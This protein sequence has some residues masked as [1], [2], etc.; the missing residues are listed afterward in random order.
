M[1][2]LTKIIGELTLAGALLLGCGEYIGRALDDRNASLAV[3]SSARNPIR[4]TKP[5]P[6]YTS[7]DYTNAT[8]N[9]KI[10]QGRFEPGFLEEVESLCQILDMN[11]MGLLSVIDYE[12]RGTFH[13]YIRNKGTFP[14]SVKKS[15]IKT[16]RSTATGLIQFTQ[17]TAEALGTTTESL[18][19]MSQH[20]QIPYLARYF[21]QHRK[22]QTNYSNPDDIALTI[23]HPA[24]VGQGSDHVIARRGRRSYHQNARL[25]NSPQDGRITAREYVQEALNR[26]YL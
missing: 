3:S 12:T 5:F 26:G 1:K 21:A 13:P 18:A 23:F 24:S 6:S 25:D 8:I 15:S 2:S 10:Q 22:A 11:C 14:S 4:E 16:R 17:A 20:Q 7:V 19:F 9:Q